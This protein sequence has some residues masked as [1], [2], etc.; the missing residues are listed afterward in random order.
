M[1]SRTANWFECK[2]QYEKVMEDGLQKKVKELY[3][4]DALSFSEAETRIIEEMAAYIS[5]EYEVVDIKKAKYKE[6]FFSDDPM[7]DRFYKAKLQ[8]ITIDEKT[9]KEKRQNVLYLVQAGS[10]NGALKNIDEVMGGTM[11]DYASVEIK[12]TALMDV[13]E[14][15]SMTNNE[16]GE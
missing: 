5:G 2:V 1:R 15:K 7:A 10:L 8:F 13:I 9:E 12:E 14:Y 11:I 6:I 3:T 4:V 16:E